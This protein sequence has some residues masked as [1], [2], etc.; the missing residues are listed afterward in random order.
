M[1]SEPSGVSDGNMWWYWHAPYGKKHKSNLYHERESTRIDQVVDSIACDSETRFDA[2]LGLKR[3]EQ[4]HQIE[5]TMNQ[6]YNL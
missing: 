2:C 3:P 1:E 4:G 6:S 5:L